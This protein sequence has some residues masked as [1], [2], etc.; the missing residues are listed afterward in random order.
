MKKLILTFGDSWTF[1]SELDKPQEHPCFAG[2]L[3]HPSEY[4]H[5]QIAKLLYD[6]YISR[7]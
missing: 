4:G 2:K 3:F 7:L 1:G 5:E 6:N